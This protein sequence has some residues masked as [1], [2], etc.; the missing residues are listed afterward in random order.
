[1]VNLGLDG[2]LSEHLGVEQ[3]GLLPLYKGRVVAFEC[4]SSESSVDSC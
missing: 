4:V 1:M 2:R 3:L